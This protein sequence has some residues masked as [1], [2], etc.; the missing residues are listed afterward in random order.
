MSRQASLHSFHPPEPQ[1]RLSVSAAIICKNEEACIAKCLESLSSFA[2]IVVADSGSTDATLAI[3]QA[4]IDRKFP[5][6]LIHKEWMGYAAQKQFAL[7]QAT[8]PWILSIDADEWLDAKLRA[9]LPQLLAADASV[10]G[11]MMRRTL[12]LDGRE[13]SLAAWTRP[14]LILRL[15]RHGRARLDPTIMVHERLIADGE[16]RVARSGVI[17]HERVLALHEQIIKEIAYARLKAQQRM[18]AGKRPIAV[19]MLLSPPIYFFRIYLWDR[20]FLCGWPGFIY[21]VTGAIYSFLTEAIH[22]QL[23]AASRNFDGAP[24]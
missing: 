21:A 14:E 11:W 23:S 9:A 15:V 10:A 3:V 22:F 20:S 4:F 16:V 8:Q 6:R 19:K 24:D 13:R 18:K 1:C 5:I 12:P 2:D 17:R 7:D